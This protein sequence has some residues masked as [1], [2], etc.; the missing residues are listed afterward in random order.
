MSKEKEWHIVIRLIGTELAIRDFSAEGLETKQDVYKYFI[1]NADE[2][3]WLM[4]V[5]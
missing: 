3:G 4:L 1:S 5:S 2:N